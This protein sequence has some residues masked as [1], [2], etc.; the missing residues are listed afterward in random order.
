MEK[1]NLTINRC[2]EILNEIFYSYIYYHNPSDSIETALLNYREEKRK[3]NIHPLSH[4]YRSILN[5][6]QLKR[7]KENTKNKFNEIEK[8]NI[9]VSKNSSVEEQLFSEEKLKESRLSAALQKQLNNNYLFTPEIDDF[10]YFSFLLLM[11]FSSGILKIDE[12]LN[13]H[14]SI[15]KDKANFLKRIVRYEMITDNVLKNE[16]IKTLFYEWV[17][18]NKEFLKSHKDSLNEPQKEKPNF[19][20]LESIFIKKPFS[21]YVDILTL[22]EPPLLEN[23]DGKYRFIGNQ[24]NQRGLVAS[25]FKELK[26]KGIV[27]SHLSREELAT[28]LSREIEDYKIGESTIDSNPQ[29]YKQLYDKQLKDMLSKVI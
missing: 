11:I 2:E 5:K 6:F 8:S 1:Y 12:I 13:Y 7:I 19:S 28:I 21:K 27:S 3:K 17:D 4:Y 16:N 29:K 9:I 14:F 10:E 22:C 26:A 25:W 24:K 23:I 20:S 15:A 18:E